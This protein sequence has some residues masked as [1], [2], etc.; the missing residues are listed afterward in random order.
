[1]S[2]GFER[3]GFGPRTMHKISCADC[4]KEAEVPFEPKEG[5][6]VYCRDCLQKHRRF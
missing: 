5:R 2:L 6:P 1:M 3:R 4:G